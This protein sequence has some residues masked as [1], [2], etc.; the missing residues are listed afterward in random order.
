VWVDQQYGLEPNP[1]DYVQAMRAVFDEARRVLHPH[2]TLW[3]NLGD[4][5]A[6]GELGRHD[7]AVATP[8]SPPG[9][10]T[11]QTPRCPR[12]PACLARTCSACRGARRWRCKPPAGSCSPGVAARPVGWIAA[13]PQLSG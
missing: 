11:A 7:A 9:K 6:T 1:E 12:P 5:Y 10:A 4:S 3:L 2:G 13:F 8:A